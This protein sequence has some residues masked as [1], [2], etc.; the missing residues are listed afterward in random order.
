[1][2]HYRGKNNDVPTG[3]MSSFVSH[4]CGDPA[5]DSMIVGERLW[6]FRG[7]EM[8]RIEG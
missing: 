2:K 5:G 7:P 1:M 8:I 4:H 6:P 3:L